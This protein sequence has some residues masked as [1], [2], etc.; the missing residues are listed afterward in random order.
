M[1]EWGAIGFDPSL[2]NKRPWWS[3]A[4]VPI[5][6]K[7]LSVPPSPSSGNHPH[8]TTVCVAPLADF[9]QQ[10]LYGAF[11][12]PPYRDDVRTSIGVC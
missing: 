9:E 2:Q 8:F 1:L 3:A 12:V 6:S 4:G 7:C 11:G 5:S 10:V